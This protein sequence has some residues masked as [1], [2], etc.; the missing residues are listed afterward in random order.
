MLCLSPLSGFQP[1]SLQALDLGPG[2]A[3]PVKGSDMESGKPRESLGM[4]S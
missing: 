3:F 1:M 2:E 4:N